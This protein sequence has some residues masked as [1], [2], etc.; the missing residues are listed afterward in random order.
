MQVKSSQ[1][2]QT[3]SFKNNLDHVTLS[4]IKVNQTVQANCPFR[5]QGSD[6]RFLQKTDF[7][8]GPFQGASLG[9]DQIP[10]L[11]GLFG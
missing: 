11:L 7:G 8:Y 5:T 9:L 2:V 6:F 10:F 1:E 3:H 4:N